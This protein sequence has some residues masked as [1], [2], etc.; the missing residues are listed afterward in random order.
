MQEAKKSKISINITERIWKATGIVCN[1]F[2]VGFWHTLHHAGISRTSIVRVRME[3]RK[4]GVRQEKGTK[5]ILHKPA[6]L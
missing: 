4:K 2:F 3:H 6:Q 5:S 1:A